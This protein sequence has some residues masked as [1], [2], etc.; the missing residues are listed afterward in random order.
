MTQF[1]SNITFADRGADVRTKQPVLLVV[2]QN[3]TYAL[4]FRSY[5]DDG[6]Q[7][8][9]TCLSGTFAG[10]ITGAEVATIG[11]ELSNIVLRCTE[12]LRVHAMKAE[13][14]CLDEAS[15]R[16]RRT[17]ADYPMQLRAADGSLI[18]STTV[19]QGCRWVLA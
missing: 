4:A 18:V 5:L 11:Y 6:E 17:L 3:S 1:Q 15:D 8:R 2:T 19:V 7:V 9:A 12:S 14:D 10:R 13:M 16:S